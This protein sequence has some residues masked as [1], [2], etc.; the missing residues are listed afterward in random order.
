MEICQKNC[1]IDSAKC[2]IQYF[3]PF[4]C[5]QEEALCALDC[6]KGVPFASQYT[7][8]VPKLSNP[9]RSMGACQQNCAVDFGGCIVDTFD[10]P[11]CMDSHTTCSV[12]CFK[13]LK[14]VDSLDNLKCELGCS[15]DISV[16]LVK[17]L[18]LK[19]CIGQ[20]EVCSNACDG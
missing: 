12:Q 14:D 5:A 6:L 7:M 17:H 11:T 16:C 10:F 9:D 2:M 4:K 8:P 18:N 15:E 20:G 13:T 19:Q 3:N 1:G